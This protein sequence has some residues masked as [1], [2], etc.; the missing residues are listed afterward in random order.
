MSLHRPSLERVGQVA[1]IMMC[2]VV[3]AVGIQRLRASPAP[4][5]PARPAPI[6]PGARLDVAEA[7]A[8]GTSRGSVVLALSTACR[9]CT[10]SMP[11]YRR[12]MA[13]DVIRD[14]RIR[15]G[16]ASLQPVDEMAQYL[17]SHQASISQVVLLRESGVPIRGTPTLVLIGRGGA[18]V[19][20]WS[21]QLGPADE[22]AAIRDI[23]QL[24]LR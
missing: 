14:G 11:F 12:L 23:R 8:P 21:G 18:V 4:V 7:L 19:N 22:E 24:A 2:V 10:A 9:Y 6:E 20:S 15:L 17:A 5:P 1:F 3:S 13:L 16:V